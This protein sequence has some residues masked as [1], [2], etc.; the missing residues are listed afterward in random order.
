MFLVLKEVSNFQA[1]S[2]KAF[3]LPTNDV[4]FYNC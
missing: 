1:L 2:E 4:V 3:A